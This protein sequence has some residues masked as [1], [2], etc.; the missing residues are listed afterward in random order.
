MQNC[1]DGLITNFYHRMEEARSESRFQKVS[2]KKFKLSDQIIT[3]P[4]DEPFDY[5]FYILA[6]YMISL[7]MVYLK[8]LE[9]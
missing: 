1:Y 3:V 8:G 6:Y 4:L 2:P 9:R 5:T 7:F